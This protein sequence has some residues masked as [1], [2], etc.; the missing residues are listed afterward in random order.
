MTTTGG[1]TGAQ[2]QTLGALLWLAIEQS[3]LP[4]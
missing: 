3:R 2:N 4:L 1:N